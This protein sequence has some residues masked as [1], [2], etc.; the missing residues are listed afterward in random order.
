MKERFTAT[1]GCGEGR[2]AQ[3]IA[4]DGCTCV[5][6]LHA[7]EQRRI[8]KIPIESSDVVAGGDLVPRAAVKIVPA[9]IGELSACSLADAAQRGEFLARGVAVVSACLFHGKIQTAPRGQ[10]LKTSTDG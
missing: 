5:G 7:R 3:L 8:E 1:E 10:P 9:C 4:K 6:V 2:K